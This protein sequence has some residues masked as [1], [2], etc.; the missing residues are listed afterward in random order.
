MTRCVL[1]GIDGSPQ[2]EAAALWAAAEARRRG[3]AVRLL[4]AW[5]W[6]DAGDGNVSQPGDLRQRASDALRGIADRIRHDHPGL[7]VEV[8]VVAED[9][10]DGLLAAAKGQELLVLGSRGLGGFAGL[11]VGSVGLAV[12]AAATVPTVLVR[13]GQ[14][15]ADRPAGTGGGTGAGA[16][17]EVV[18]GLDGRR[19]DDTVVEFAV[20]EAQL[21]GCRLRV[22]H[23][24]DPAPVWAYGGLMPPLVDLTEQEA[25]EA[26]LI[27]PVVTAL[28]AEHPGLDIVEEVRLGGGA[29]AL[30]EATS[31]RADLVV[32]GRREHRHRLG[33]R[34]G[35]VA[36]A[37]LHHCAAPVVVVP[38]T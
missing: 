29:R 17:R 19:T 8:A 24:W 32:V 33:P 1:T 9:P 15:P 35:P 5:P 10:V 34:L 38:H 4:H 16:G 12:A 20:A 14:A 22:V 31:T 23:G 2:S 37:V 25:T 26:A 7:P 13:L 30:L 11:L 28:R 21:R 27:S 36:H 3:C 18:V 6:L